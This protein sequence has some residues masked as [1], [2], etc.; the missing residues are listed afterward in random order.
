MPG[1]TG[2][3]MIGYYPEPP[4]LRSREVDRGAPRPLSVLKAVIVVGI[5]H[6]QSCKG[7]LL[8]SD[9]HLHFTNNA[10]SRTSKIGPDFPLMPCPCMLRLGIHVP[11]M[12]L[13]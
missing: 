12:A 9:S 6:C 2:L 8:V 13:Q 4:R 1:P 5:D 3:I 10:R 7:G 11:H